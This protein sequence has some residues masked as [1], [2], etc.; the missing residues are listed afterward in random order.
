MWKMP[1]QY[2]KRLQDVFHLMLSYTIYDDAECEHHQ[3]CVICHDLGYSWGTAYEFPQ[4]KHLC[5]AKLDIHNLFRS[6]IR[7]FSQVFN[8]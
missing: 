4:L 8:R 1:L 3:L 7:V 6:G 2:N 5:S